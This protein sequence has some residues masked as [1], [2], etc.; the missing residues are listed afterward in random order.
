MTD[1]TTRINNGI[2]DVE[3]LNEEMLQQLKIAGID[4]II[5]ELQRQIDEWLKTK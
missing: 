3:A 5:S 1:Y 4:D 2:G